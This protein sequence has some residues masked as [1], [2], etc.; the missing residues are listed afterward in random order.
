MA[1]RSSHGRDAKSRGNGDENRQHVAQHPEILVVAIVVATGQSG[2]V[3]P[4]LDLGRE[5]RPPRAEPKMPV[6]GIRRGAHHLD[7]PAE[8]VR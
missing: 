3:Q 2:A 1:W 5:L 8:R 6:L 7:L 4:K